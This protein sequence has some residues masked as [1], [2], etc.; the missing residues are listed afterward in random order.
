[1]PEL[2]ARERKCLEYL[3]PLMEAN[4][5]MIGDAIA[6]EIPNARNRKRYGE[7]VAESLHRNNPPL[8]GWLPE[9]SAW[10]ITDA[11]RAALKET[12]T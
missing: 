9:M 2:T 6:P 5:A 7:V 8:V 11:G 10:R 3:S 12:R 1:M 4:D